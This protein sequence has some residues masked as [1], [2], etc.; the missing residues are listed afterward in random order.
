VWC[1]Q[2]PYAGKPLL[3]VAFGVTIEGLRLKI[4]DHCPDMFRQLMGKCWETN[5]EGALY[6][7][8]AHANTRDALV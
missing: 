7:P 8:R 5:P 6:S 2:K 1:R 4:P 3:E